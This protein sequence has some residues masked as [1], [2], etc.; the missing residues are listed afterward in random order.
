MAAPTLAAAVGAWT[1]KP[2]PGLVAAAWLSVGPIFMPYAADNLRDGR[3]SVKAGMAA[4][5]AA[6]GVALLSGIAG[7]PRLSR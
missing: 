7:L 6:N 4:Q 2:L 3:T 5:L 1:R